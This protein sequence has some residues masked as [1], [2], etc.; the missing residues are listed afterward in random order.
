MHYRNAHTTIVYIKETSHKKNLI[1]NNESRER[2][3]LHDNAKVFLES[4]RFMYRDLKSK[5]HS[6]KLKL[7]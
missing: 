5:S 7:V 3:L 1:Q 6:S 2:P 4:F